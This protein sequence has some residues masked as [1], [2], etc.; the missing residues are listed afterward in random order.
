MATPLTVRV[1]EHQLQVFRRFWRGSATFYV[2]NPLLFLA[3]IGFGLGGLV[4]ES[5]GNVGGV[6]YDAFVAP[7]LLAASATLRARAESPWPLMARGEGGGAL[8]A[9]GAA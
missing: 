9:P 7:G 8:P 3:A 6:P 2:L 5:T 1:V 4:Q